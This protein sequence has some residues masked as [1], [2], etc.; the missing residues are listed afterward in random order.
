MNLRKLALASLLT[1][2]AGIPAVTL[3]DSD[4]GIGAGASAPVD[5]SFRVVIPQFVYF[6]IGSS[7]V[8]GA[9]DEVV[10]DLSV[11]PGVEPGDGTDV[12]DSNSPVPV[13]LRSNAATVT[14]TA[15]PLAGTGP[16]ALGSTEISGVS[17]SASIPVPAFGASSAPVAGPVNASGNWT[18]TYTNA[19]VY[20]AGTY[21]DT[22]TYTA[23][24]P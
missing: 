12:A 24:T 7:A 16:L 6:Q 21:T 1:A 14:I 8:I 19:A 10:F 13:V 23:A 20:A 9:L 3:A 4:F 11:P 5:L 17:S 22:V 2:G 15:Q 18:F